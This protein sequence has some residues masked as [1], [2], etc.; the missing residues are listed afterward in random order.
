MANYWQ[1]EMVGYGFDMVPVAQGPYTWTYSFKAMG[2]AFTEHNVVYNNN[3]V[4]R[5]CLSNTAAKSLNKEGIETV[6]PV[7]IQTNRRIDAT[8]SSLN[9][10]VIYDKHFEEY[11]NYIG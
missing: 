9:A 2:A 3:P 10:W 1:A 8:V 7:K 4:M 11:M 5:W 6:Q